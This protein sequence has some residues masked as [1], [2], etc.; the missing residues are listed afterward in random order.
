R[1]L[2]VH[3]EHDQRAYETQTVYLL[4]PDL[5]VAPVIEPGRRDWTVYLPAGADWT[6]LWSGASHSG[7]ST[8]KVEAPIG[9]P[10]VFWRKGS[11]FGELFAQIAT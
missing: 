5:L 8:V 3:F 11:A 10:P 6:H 2:F 7:G 1:P 4:G 9:A